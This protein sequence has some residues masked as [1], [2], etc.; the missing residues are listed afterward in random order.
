MVEKAETQRDK[1]M[2]MTI[3]DMDLSV[4]LKVTRLSSGLDK[5]SDLN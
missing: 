4:L 1:V 5:T 2:E 3:D